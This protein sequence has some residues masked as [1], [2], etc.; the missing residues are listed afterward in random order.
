M[1]AKQYKKPATFMITSKKNRENYELECKKMT[2]IIAQFNLYKNIGSLHKIYNY[3]NLRQ[4]FDWVKLFKAGFIVIHRHRVNGTLKNE[5]LLLKQKL[6]EGDEHLPINRGPPKGTAINKDVTAFDTAVREM[7]EETSI[8]LYN[9]SPQR[10]KIMSTAINARRPEVS[11]M[12]IYFVLIVKDR[13]E[14][15]ICNKEIE[16]Y[17]WYDMSAG[18]R[19]I[20][21]VSIP[22]KR[23]LAVLEDTDIFEVV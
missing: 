22:T 18:L 8:D 7:K 2:S 9:L 16:S 20:K 17:E 14:I 13:V 21:D 19:Y 10:I 12:N 6:Y 4:I 3:A 11:E 23:L 1:V 5:L 15:N